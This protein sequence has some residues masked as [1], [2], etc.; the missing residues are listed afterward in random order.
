MFL[1]GS[2]DQGGLHS[3]CGPGWRALFSHW[4]NQEFVCGTAALPHLWIAGAVA[5]VA[6]AGRTG[7]RGG[8]P[9][10]ILL[11]TLFISVVS[12]ANTWWGERG[13]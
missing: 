5:L 13:G 2:T 8:A 6:S 11:L 3:A 7:L 12:V 1:P 10:F 9:G 4:H